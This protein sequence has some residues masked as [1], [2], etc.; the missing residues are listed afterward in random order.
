MKKKMSVK[1]LTYMAMCVALTAICSWI[2][3]PA[4][5]PFTLQTFAVALTLFLLG[6][7]RGTIA[8]VTYVLLGAVGVPVFAG[9][10]GG[11]GA[12][13]GA[14]GGYIVG[15]IFMGLIYWVMTAFLG[16]KYYVKIIASVIGLAICYL[17]GTIWFVNIYSSSNEAIGF[18]TGIA[19]CVTPYIIPDII[20]LILATGL[21]TTLNRYVKF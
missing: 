20:K 5:V 17:F 9:L 10:S 16:E 12:L 8:I 2:T 3:I 11:L 15:F 6:G 18:A 1:E 4:T 21:S 14:T 19:W 7:K 13:L